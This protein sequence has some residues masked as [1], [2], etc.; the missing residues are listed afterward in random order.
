MK[1]INKKM[2]TI[3]KKMKFVAIR[4]DRIGMQLYAIINAIYYCKKYN[5]EYVHI[6]LDDSYI[7]YSKLFKLGQDYETMTKETFERE[8]QYTKSEIKNVGHLFSLV[9]K[10]RK[11]KKRLTNVV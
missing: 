3:N 5:L 2:K 8:H 10:K 6:P 1:T 7:E 9:K 4:D 11:K